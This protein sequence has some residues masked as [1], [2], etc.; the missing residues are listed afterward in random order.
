M[1][2]K[3]LHCKGRTGRCHHDEDGQPLA[4]HACWN[5]SAHCLTTSQTRKSANGQSDQQVSFQIKQLRIR[6]LTSQLQVVHLEISQQAMHSQTTQPPS[7]W[8]GHYGVGSEPHAAFLGNTGKSMA[9][10]R[11]LMM[12]LQ[13]SCAV[14][15]KNS[16]LEALWVRCI[17][18]HHNATDV[19]IC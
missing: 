13:A 7:P 18:C 16:C 9:S 14:R 1:S 17:S 4:T 10:S 6:S 2:N 11:L 3:Y 5:L 15:E 19:K 12:Q 8:H